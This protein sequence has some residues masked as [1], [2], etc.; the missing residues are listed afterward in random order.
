MI[1]IKGTIKKISVIL[2]L[3]MG[4]FMIPYTGTYAETKNKQEMSATDQDTTLS[5]DKAD[6]NGNQITISYTI[7]SNK[8]ESQVQ[9][10]SLMEKPEIL[11]DG[12][13]ISIRGY[14]NESKLGKGIYKGE[15]ILT[16]PNS[17]EKPF[18]VTFNT[19]RVLNINGQWTIKFKL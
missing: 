9:V 6:F 7:H 11:I 16:T 3:S 5:I 15:M 17:L 8:D 10:P 1:K 12:K 2:A 13:P 14:V 4:V 18:T 19:H